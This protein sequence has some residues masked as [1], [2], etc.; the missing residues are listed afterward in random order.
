MLPLLRPDFIFTENQPPASDFSQIRDEFFNLA[1]K[2]GANIDM[3]VRAT[4]DPNDLIGWYLGSGPRSIHTWLSNE[5]KFLHS[6]RSQE[7]NI[8]KENFDHLIPLASS[9]RNQIKSL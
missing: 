9:S 1:L 6:W 7:A 3:L 5:P 4:N 8:I 2:Q